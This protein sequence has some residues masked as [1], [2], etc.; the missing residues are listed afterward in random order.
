MKVTTTRLIVI[1]AAVVML[2]A[3]ALKSDVKASLKVLGN[4]FT[5][6]TTR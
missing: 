1:A 5:I 2:A 6:E 4:G 3:L